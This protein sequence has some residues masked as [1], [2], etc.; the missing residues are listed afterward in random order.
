V[1][2][3]LLF[4][5]AFIDAFLERWESDQDYCTANAGGVTILIAF[6]RLVPPPNRMLE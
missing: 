4:S 1:S 3:H 2:C 6:P 5:F